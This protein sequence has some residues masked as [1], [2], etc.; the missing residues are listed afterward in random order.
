MNTTG[1]KRKIF[2]IAVTDKEGTL[3]RM[4][5]ETMLELLS[6]KGEFKD[7]Y[8]IQ[9]HN[10][11]TAQNL[12]DSI[13]DAIR[14]SKYEGYIIILDCLDTKKGLCN[15][16][17][18]FEFGAVKYFGKPFIVMAANPDEK[19]PFDV[20]DLNI[21]PIPR[22]ITEYIKDCYDNKDKIDICEKIDN[23]F[24]DD[25]KRKVDNFLVN[26]YEKYKVSFKD[27]NIEMKNVENKDL[28]DELLKIKK[29]LSNTAEYIEGEDAAFTALSESVQKANSSLRTTRFANQ[30][31]VGRK[32]SAEQNEFMK[33]L[34]EVS[35]KLNDSF[36]RIICNNHPAKWID[37]Y[38][39]LFYGKN[40]SKV[41]I[42]KEDFS[43]HFELVIIDEKIAFIHF[44]QKD[45]SK[46]N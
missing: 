4:F 37:I 25:E 29:L 46:Q 31:I 9:P 15:P 10:R 8:I 21:E 42:R 1:K 38:N 36:E 43:I 26:L 11:A 23:D 18:M 20:S 41:Y 6:Q 5:Q 39:I 2:L 34:Y 22:N 14:G 33:S 3:N 7:N 45:Y 44:Y 16:N 30:S 24:D 40:G 13:D 28:L 27:K 32:A 12:Y 17:V 19:Y 35:D